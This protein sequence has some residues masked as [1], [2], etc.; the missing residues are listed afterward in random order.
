[1]DGQSPR[2][3]AGRLLA[4]AAPRGAAAGDAA[5]RHLEPRPKS[6]APAAG[7]EAGCG[8]AAGVGG[9]GGMLA[10]PSASPRRAQ[11]RP[12]LGDPPH[13][14]PRHRAR[15]RR[16]RSR[17]ALAV[18]GDGPGKLSPDEQLANSASRKPR[19]EE[20]KRFGLGREIFFFFWRGKLGVVVI[21]VG[22]RRAPEE[23]RQARAE[24][25]LKASIQRNRR[26]SG[27]AL[28]IMTV[29]G[30]RWPLNFL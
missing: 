3:P 4:L 18:P 6:A 24:E 21:V 9:P 2:P 22:G 17:P 28:R 1:M 11:R 16:E 27:R 15:A 5:G 30:G 26:E 13:L 14:S 8:A 19:A 23:S 25:T 20:R 12:H 10:G 29:R 7:R